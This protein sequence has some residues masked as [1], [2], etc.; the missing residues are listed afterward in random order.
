M[1]TNEEYV[2]LSEA[3]RRLG[4]SWPTAV[5]W[6]RDGTLP[7]SRPAPGVV[8]VAVKDIPKV[9]KQGRAYVTQE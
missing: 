2:T 4:V 8:L 6:S 5:R 1:N 9:R 7:V 3:Q